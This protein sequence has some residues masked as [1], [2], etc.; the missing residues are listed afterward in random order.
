MAAGSPGEHPAVGIDLFTL[1]RVLWRRKLLVV[2]VLAACVGI[3]I[4]R[5]Q[6][7]VFQYSAELRVTPVQADSNSM[8]SNLSGLASLAGVSL[9]KNQA[10]SPFGL[11]VE[12]LRGREIANRL[13]RDPEIMKVIFADQWDSANGAWKQPRASLNVTARRLLK[14]MLGLP[15]MAWAPP[16][17]EDLHR[18]M[19]DFVEVTEDQKRNIVTIRFYHKDRQF[20]G[21]F[22]QRLHQVSDQILRQ[23]T[24]ARATTYVT[25]LERR[26][27]S[28]SIGEHRVALADALGAQERLLMMA[29]SSAPFAA[30]PFG[31]V[32]MSAAPEKPRPAKMLA[33]GGALGIALGILAALLAENRVALIGQFR[34]DHES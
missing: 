6:L 32:L 19:V 24:L 4:V 23:R 12:S 29:S 7:S 26:I 15:V 8:M 27:G 30:E 9:P 18:Y 16:A 13:S 14:R 31:S 34:S 25:Y 1:L 5:L 21:M 11:Y 2:M 20:A 22:V 3:T 10:V 17:G 33:L 28:T